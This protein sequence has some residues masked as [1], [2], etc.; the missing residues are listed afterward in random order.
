[1]DCPTARLHLVEDQRGHLD[2]PKAAALAAHLERCPDCA[3]EEKAERLVTEQLERHLPQHAAPLGLK[4]RLAGQWSASPPAPSPRRAGGRRGG[5]AFTLADPRRRWPATAAAVLV[6]S[7]VTAGVAG[8]LAGR[9]PG[10]GWGA[11]SDTAERLVTE[12]VNDHLRV[13]AKAPALD[14]QSSDMHQVRPWLTGRLDFAPVI[15][16]AGD[17]DFPLR[18]GAVEYFLDRRAAVAVY[19]R[20]LHTVTLIVTRGDG[21]PWPQAAPLATNARGFNV[22]LWTRGGLGYALVSDLDPGE[23]ARLAARLGG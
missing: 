1:M 10:V 11:R 8:W 13:L 5:G 7:V 23:L 4:R 12:A 17:T 3:H 18:G 2:P 22:R 15:P 14:V 6:A 20:R 9:A 16:F 19:S 21:L